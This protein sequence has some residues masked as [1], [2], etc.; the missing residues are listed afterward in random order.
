MFITKEWQ[1]G[2]SIFED[3]KIPCMVR[4]SRSFKNPHWYNMAHVHS[5]DTELVF[6]SSGKAT[7]T[8]NQKTFFVEKGDILIVEEGFIHSTASDPQEPSDIFSLSIANYK[9]RGLKKD[10]LLLSPNTL[11]VMRAGTHEEFLRC[12]WKELQFYQ[13]REDDV[14]ASI[15][16]MI[17]GS[18]ASL[19]YLLFL[20]QTDTYEIPSPH[21]TQDLLIYI[22]EHYC[23]NITLERLSKEFH[24]SSGHISHEFSKVFGISPINYAINLK[25]DHAKWLLLQ[26]EK[27]MME[28]AEA[29]SY[30][31]LQH[32]TNIFQKRV[33][34]T[35]LEFKN[36]YEKNTNR[37][38][39]IEEI[40][41]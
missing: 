13:E 35:P 9:I 10:H 28:I 32:F 41:Y 26:S 20:E 18:I 5:S 6:I 3:G 2:P 17:A 22:Y 25:L 7:F 23:E 39:S 30:Q 14:S 15:C 19:Y 33:G 40:R 31:N 29:V 12:C 11:P 24:M 8:I 16:D 36:A 37:T 1:E 4:L 21:F 27:S 34:C 38:L